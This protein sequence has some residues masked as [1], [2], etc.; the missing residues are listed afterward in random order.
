MKRLFFIPAIICLMMTACQQNN[1]PFLGE[2]NT[3][4]DVPP[5]EQIENE[6]YMPAFEEGIKQQKA[7]IE[8]IVNNPEAPTFDNTI[9]ALDLSGMLLRRVE[10][11]FFSFTEAMSNDTLQEI[12]AEVSP[13]LSAHSDDIMLNEAL[14]ERIKTVYD[15]RANENL[16]RAQER[17]LEQY[18]NNFVRAGALLSA[19]DKET[20]RTINSELSTLSLQF[21]NNSLAENNAFELL[22]ENEA[23]LAGL[24]AGV[25]A[26]AK[27]EA[28][29]K[30]KE[31]WL[32]NLS[33]PSRIPFLQYADNRDLREKL[34]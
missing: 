22:I 26:A 23:D 3:P 9:K 29:A 20:L 31:G 1:N 21:G 5:F 28:A 32:F 13:M 19:E 25:V 14:F 27:E 8:A 2:Y 10:L 33:A 24:P 16:D 15:N 34:Y 17:L 30:G 7:E 12:A 18:Y 4:F 6:H 11:T